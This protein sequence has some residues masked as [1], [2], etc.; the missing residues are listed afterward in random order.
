[1]VA[2]RDPVRL[3]VP[4][5]DTPFEE[6]VEKIVS[7]GVEW[8]QNICCAICVTCVAYL[9]VCLCW[10]LVTNESDL[11]SFLIRH[12]IGT[13]VMVIVF[14]VWNMFGPDE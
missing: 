7:R 3:E 14:I 6:V 11:S 8:I 5:L 4:G 2:A 10:Q 13:Y 9:A 1:M 12:T